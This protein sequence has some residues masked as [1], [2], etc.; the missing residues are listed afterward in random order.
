MQL[1]ALFLSLLMALLKSW[2][3]ITIQ[4]NEGEKG[5]GG[6]DSLQLFILILPLS[7]SLAICLSVPLL[8]TLII[9]LSLTIYLSVSLL[10]TL[11]FLFLC[12]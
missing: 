4:T 11:I 9:S 6:V 1:D 7:L 5:E 8:F 10:F 3:T 12:L 2:N